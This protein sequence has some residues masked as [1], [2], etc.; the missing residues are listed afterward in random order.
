MTNIGAVE[1]GLED[2]YGILIELIRI[3]DATTICRSARFECRYANASLAL[4]FP[5]R[6]ATAAKALLAAAAAA[7]RG[8]SGPRRGPP[9]ATLLSQEI[10]SAA[11]KS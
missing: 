11:Y 3:I 2:R 10:E 8:A 5:L 9:D 1:H 7:A 4:H 6:P